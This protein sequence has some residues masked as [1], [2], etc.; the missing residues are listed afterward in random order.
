MTEISREQIITR[1]KERKAKAIFVENFPHP[2]K[3]L[4]AVTEPLIYSK[5]RVVKSSRKIYIKRLGLRTK[6]DCEKLNKELKT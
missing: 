5:P 2:D 4:N 6:E 3:N 1:L